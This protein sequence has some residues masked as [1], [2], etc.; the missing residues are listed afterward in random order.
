MFKARLATPAAKPYVENLYFTLLFVLRAVTKVSQGLMLQGQAD[1][2]LLLMSWDEYS[3]S[4]VYA[5]MLWA[6]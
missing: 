5:V 4:N 6:D 1:G 3:L 2:V